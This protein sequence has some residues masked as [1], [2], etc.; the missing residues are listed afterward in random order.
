M[1][2]VVNTATYS[3]KINQY[4]GY[5]E[6]TKLELTSTFGKKVDLLPF[7]LEMN[8]FE[9]LNAPA[10]TGSVSLLDT[11]NL[12]KNTPII[13]EEVI[14]ITVS[15][16][17]AKM[18]NKKFRIYKI[19]DRK[20]PNY[21]VLS[22]N[23]HFCSE[24]LYINSFQRVSKAYQVTHYEDAVKDVLKTYLK[25]DKEILV[26]TTKLR[27][28]FI[29]P[30]WQP[31]FATNWMASRSQDQAYVGG[32]FIFYENLDR[33]NFLAV[34]NLL[35]ETKNVPFAEVSID[36][37]RPTVDGRIAYDSRQKRDVMRFESMEVVKSLDVLE[38]MTFGMYKNMVRVVDVSVKG[39]ETKTYDYQEEFGNSVHLKGLDGK[40]NPL[41]TENHLNVQFDIQME[42]NVFIKAKG[43]FSNEPD[44]GFQVEDWFSPRLSQMHQMNN[45]V[46]RGTLPGQMEMRVGMLVKFRMPN[47]ENLDIGGTVYPDY[48]YSGNYL[49]TSLRRIFQKN[50]FYCVIEMIKDSMSLDLET[51]DPSSS[52]KNL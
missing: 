24:E 8:L 46:I 2:V 39:S 48:A 41:S 7:F 38:N 5:Y 30:N 9:D 19:S 27:Q 22:Y 18:E 33:F 21:G 31:F 12:I 14:E 16:Q 52:V 37:M 35:D 28:S 6:I 29:I 3:E 25:S 4:P 17:Y 43:L 36:P 40:T 11:K 44:G 50:K 23:L 47:P 26:G 32:N 15:D 20:Q 45:F 42:N 1:G 10:L 49:I 51:L 13:G 34:E